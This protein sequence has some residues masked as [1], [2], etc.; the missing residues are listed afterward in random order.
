MCGENKF[1][2]TGRGRAMALTEGQLSKKRQRLLVYQ[3]LLRGGTM[4]PAQIG[5]TPVASFS[6]KGNQKWSK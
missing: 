1:V 6:E 2:G 5:D 3:S 4:D